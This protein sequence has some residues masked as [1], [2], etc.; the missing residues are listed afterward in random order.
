MTFYNFE[1]LM[2]FLTYA[3]FEQQV[4][5]ILETLHFMSSFSFEPILA[6][7]FKDWRMCVI[8]Q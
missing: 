5:T 4:W 1:E 2:E 3:E 6:E 7:T 8:K